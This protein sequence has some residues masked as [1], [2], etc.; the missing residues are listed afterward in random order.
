M[1]A[2]LLVSEIAVGQRPVEA[3]DRAISGG[4]YWTSD[5]V[6]GLGSA[7]GRLV[8][9]TT[10]FRGNAK[11]WPLYKDAAYACKRIGVFIETI[12]KQYRQHTALDWLTPGRIRP[13]AFTQTIDGKAA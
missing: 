2:G 11:E 10:R 1:L 7:T 8:G 5:L 6:L 3:D 9:C 4:G 12:Y 13:E